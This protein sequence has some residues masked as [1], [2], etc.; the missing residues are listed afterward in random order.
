MGLA[1][2]IDS[3]IRVAQYG[4]SSVISII[5]DD[6]IEKMNAFYSEKFELPYQEITQKIQDYRAKRVT[7]Y[8]NLVDNIV[9][10]KF[11][12]F[13]TELAES[14]LA[15][16]NFISMLPNKSEIKE[17]LQNLL[18]DGIAFK[19]NIKNYLENNLKSGEIDVNIMTKVDKDNFENGVQLPTEFNDAHA[20]LRGFANSSLSSSVVLS[21]GMNP[22][23]Y[24]YFESFEDFFPDENSFLKKKIILK[25]SDFRSA[26]IQGN[27]LAKKGL[28]VSEYRIESGLNCGGHAFATEGYLLGP[29]MEEFKTKKDQLI[30]SAHDLMVKALTI[31]EKFAPENPLE[32]KITVQG[33]VGTSSEHDFL[34]DNY[35]V[36]AVG[37]GT[38]FLLVP[39]ATSVDAATRELLM[40]AKEKDL[41]LSHI[42]P[43]GIPFNTL[44][45]TT[46]EFFKQKRIQDNKAGSS[47]PKKFLALSKEMGPEGI[48]TASKKYQDVKLA[49][50][51][52][53]KDNYSEKTFENA[54][55][56]ITEK[57]CL[58]VGLANASYLENDIKVKGQAQGV[59]ICPGPNMAYFDQEVSL[60]EMT[61]HIY[62]NANVLSN[63]N[64]PNMFVKELKMYVD[65]LKNE[66]DTISQEVTANQ[67]KKWNSFKSNLLEG[68]AYYQNLFT[69][70]TSENKKIQNALFFYKEDLT[71]FKIPELETA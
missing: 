53:T 48:C 25:V 29:I 58:C 57:S 70:N 12:N 36:D 64:R 15:L 31:K 35:N 3:P 41:Y 5:D 52:A 19:E 71:E 7:A 66:I 24:S 37:W 16:E 20:S 59:V 61:K 38:P 46:N 21:A 45:G 44:K 13:K 10:V 49:E 50:L 65:Y 30:K 67:I 9:K 34:I 28:W 23:L 6:L 2:T 1:Y 69:A 68:I 40:N 63:N 32:L 26:M 51:E 62:G 22:R 55:T 33:G 54:K 43:L 11:E 27:F 47:C 39:E 8:L 14:K 18:D 4:I 17:G 60:L 56:K 42:S